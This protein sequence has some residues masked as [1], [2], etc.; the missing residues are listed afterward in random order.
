VDFGLKRK[1]VKSFCDRDKK[2][3]VFDR[4]SLRAKFAE[5]KRAISI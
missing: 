3:T 2:V 4:Q 5:K 1:K